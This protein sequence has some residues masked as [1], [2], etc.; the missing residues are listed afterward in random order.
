[1]S[2]LDLNDPAAY[3]RWV[4][5]KQAA[6]DRRSAQD[7]E[8]VVDIDGDG[9]L[10]D[11]AIHSIGQQ[12]KRYNFAIYRMCGV[13]EDHL[14]AL[15]NVGRQL[16]LKELDKNLCAREDR[17]TKLTVQDQGRANLYI[18]YT[19]KAIGWHTDGYYN[20]MHQRV[21][22]MVLHCEQPAAQG[23]ENR[24]LDPDM[25]YIHLRDQN[26]MFINALSQ[27]GVMCIPENRENGQ[28]I[29]PQT[30]SAVFVE[31]DDHALA[32]RFSKRK[33]NIIWSDDILTQEALDCLFKFLESDTPYIIS[34][35][36]AA[37]EGVVNNNVLHTRS[38]FTDDPSHKRVYYRARYY[39]RINIH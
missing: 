33:H 28:L 36:L 22:A 16:G 13:I 4:D 37:G 19:N 11:Q 10:P 20:P 30:C 1:M 18:P 34:Y 26:P 15:K 35:R 24:L 7:F 9:H 32:M 8:L 39:N 27:P 12:I 21:L 23:G 3:Q 14:L 6:Y 17:I 31:E 2:H 5:A 38:A 25:V 29:R